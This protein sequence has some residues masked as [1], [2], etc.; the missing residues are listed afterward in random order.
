MAFSF[1][2]RKVLV[3]GG[4]GGLGHAIVQKF[5]ESGAT[6]YA[7]DIHEERLK[8]LKQEFPNVE[9]VMADI[10]KWDEIRE[11][12]NALGPLHHLVNNAGLGVAPSCLETTEQDVDKYLQ[13]I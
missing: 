8:S 12:I 6:V 1:A 3:S 4:A 9:I 10:T 5:Y 13:S 7:I 11:T 2:G